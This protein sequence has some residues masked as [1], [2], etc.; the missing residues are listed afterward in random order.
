MFRLLRYFTITSAIILAITVAVLVQLYRSDHLSEHMS[1]AEEESVR[2]ATSFAN[3]LWPEFAPFFAEAPNLDVEGLRQRPELR[4]IDI[5]L[6]SMAAGLPIVKLKIYSATGLTLYSPDRKEIGE[7]RQD[8]P[9][10][11]AVRSEG[12]AKS[13]AT[14]RKT[15]QAFNGIIKKRHIVETYYPVRDSAQNLIGVLE[16]YSDITS[17]TTRSEMKTVWLAGLLVVAFISLF[18]TLFLIVRRADSIIRTQYLE[19]E[20]NHAEL[21]R[22]VNQLETSRK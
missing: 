12:R 22:K 1:M 3:S 9:F 10:I 5:A 11:L 17:S 7:D 21:E 2:L 20:Q 14:F 19:L 18:G 4:L 15:F 6:Q 8:N 16:I 13:N